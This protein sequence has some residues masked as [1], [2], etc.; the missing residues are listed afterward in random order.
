[1]WDA[2][3]REWRSVVASAV[4][5]ALITLGLLFALAAV[6]GDDDNRLLSDIRDASR[7][8]ICVLA[9][10]VSDD[11]RNEAAVK[12]CLEENGL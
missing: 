4:V 2:L 6:F 9:L 8:E 3:R 12:R 7:A 10:P 1:M 5:T 11:G